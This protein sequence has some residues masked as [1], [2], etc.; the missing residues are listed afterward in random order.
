M[1]FSMYLKIC[2]LD[3][4]LFHSFVHLMGHSFSLSGK[5]SSQSASTSCPAAAE[6]QGPAGVT[7]TLTAVKEGSEATETDDS[8][9][10]SVLTSPS[11]SFLFSGLA[12]GQY[13]HTFF[14]Y[15]IFLHCSTVTFDPQIFFSEQFLS[16]FNYSVCM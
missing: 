4:F 1:N 15:C 8:P 12:I 6:G 9:S 14:I 13:Y 3:C 11:G 10:V 16:I 5:I 7:V 2:V